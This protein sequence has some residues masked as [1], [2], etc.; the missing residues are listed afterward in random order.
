MAPRRKTIKLPR[1]DATMNGISAWYKDVFERLGWMILAKAKGFNDKI[2]S[3]K[4]S[5]KRLLKTI[6]HVSAEYES[7]NRKHDLGVLRMNLMALWE[8]VQRDF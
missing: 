2:V 5:I 3:Y 7:A 4:N 6:D 8:H 1:N